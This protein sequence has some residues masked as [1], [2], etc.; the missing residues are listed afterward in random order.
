MTTNDTPRR[1]RWPRVAVA[2][3]A[4]AA[5]VAVPVYLLNSAFGQGRDAIAMTEQ[6]TGPMIASLREQ[7]RRAG[8]DIDV[9]W[10]AGPMGDMQMVE[11]TLRGPTPELTGRAQFMVDTD[12]GVVSPEDPLARRLAMDMSPGMQH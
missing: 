7:A 2:L 10:K 11:I 1:A 9:S 6:A 12:R 5:I 4:V 8:G 3:G